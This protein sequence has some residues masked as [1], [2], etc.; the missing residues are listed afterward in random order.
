MSLSTS[1]PSVV[2]CIDCKSCAAAAKEEAEE[3]DKQ[4]REIAEALKKEEDA[5]KGTSEDAEAITAE[6]TVNTGSQSVLQVTFLQDFRLSRGFKL[7]IRCSCL[8][9]T[10]PLCLPPFFWRY[11]S[12]HVAKHSLLWKLV[13]GEMLP[14]RSSILEMHESVHAL[15]IPRTHHI[16]CIPAL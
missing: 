8:T 7:G 11:K 2:H 13:A 16:A 4:R 1:Q 12:C 9:S 3:A 6:D 5:K 15:Y 14:S 10:P